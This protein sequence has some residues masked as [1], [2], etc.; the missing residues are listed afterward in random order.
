M[1]GKNAIAGIRGRQI[2]DS[3]GR[4]TVE[5]DVVFAGGA[6]GRAAVP[7]GAS[8][9]RFEAHEL[10]DGDATLYRGRAVRRAVSNVNTVLAPLLLGADG[11]DQNAIDQSMRTED[12]TPDLSRLGANAVLGVSLAVCQAAA[13]AAGE[14]L[15]RRIAA[16]A[17]DA[18]PMLPV[19][20]VNMLS[21]G[22]HARQ[23]MDLQD[24][25][26]IPIGAASFS[27]ALHM[28]AKMRDAANE[29]AERRAL[30]T[31]LADEGGLSP[32]FRSVEAALD[33]MVEAAEEAGLA[34]GH[35]VGFAIDLAANGL[36][37]SNG[38]YVFVRGDLRFSAAELVA[39]VAGWVQRYP[40]V[41]I[42]DV[43]HEEDW[44][45]WS[46]ITERLGHEIQ[47]IGD[48]L[49]TTSPERIRYGIGRGAANCA[50]IKLN[51]NGTLSG[52][53]Q[54]IA[55]ARGGGY[56][57]VISARSGETEDSFIADLAVGTAAGQIK[58]G[59]LRSSERLAKYNQLLRLEEHGLSYAGAKMPPTLPR[60]L[61][62]QRKFDVARV[63]RAE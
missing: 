35:D 21:G 23:G 48:D 55:T 29:V 8:T 56:G 60:G 10:R 40:I 4:P 31:L 19:P 49:F 16:L 13:A 22:M 45:H 25:L 63:G 12:G 9:G 52:T 57:I 54:A 62:G 51:Q 3:R 27:D 15:Y 37:G 11:V 30:S 59:S 43:L 14:P 7:S 33:F 20:M 58:I 26:A 44:S 42:E 6:R 17:G 28:M 53:L 2:L 36:R 24:F 41:S 50:L 61:V 34:P 46:A 39:A 47:I 38:D 32:G 18:E 1:S 5:V